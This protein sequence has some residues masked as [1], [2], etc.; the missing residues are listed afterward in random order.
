MTQGDT[1]QHNLVPDLVAGLTTGIANIP[2]T[3]VS[4]ILSGTNPV[5]GLYASTTSTGADK[6]SNWLPTTPPGELFR[7]IQRLYNPKGQI[8]NG[9]W[10]PPAIKR[11]D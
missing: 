1:K 6:E 4:V 5:F 11:I 10:K 8:L 3:V 9:L 2:D 7:I